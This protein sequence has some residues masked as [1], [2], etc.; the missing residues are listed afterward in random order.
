[1]EG[2]AEERVT[3]PRPPSRLQTLSIFRLGN[4]SSGVTVV[5]VR[6][7]VRSGHCQGS[8]LRAR[9]DD[10][11]PRRPRGP[12]DFLTAA[13][14][15]P[16]EAGPGDEET[17]PSP[18]SPEPLPPPAVVN[19]SRLFSALRIFPP[20]IVLSSICFSQECVFFLF[21]AAFILC[22]RISFSTVFSKR[23]FLPRLL[24]LTHW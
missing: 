22:E 19:S 11:R 12:R 21:F 9:W 16:E 20:R 6:T 18:P 15:P 13:Q 3:F 24:S 2:W 8:D 5:T 7:R 4:F 1:M 23:P 17:P 10:P 14:P